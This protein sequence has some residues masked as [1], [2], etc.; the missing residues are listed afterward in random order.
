VQ[1]RKGDS[2][3]ARATLIEA[4]RAAT[5]VHEENIA[6]EAWLE[7]VGIVFFDR[8]MLPELD[9]WILGAE[10]AATRLAKDNPLQTQLAF[11]V[12]SAQLLHG[13]IDDA[14][15]KLER[16]LAE[17]KREPDK[18][19]YDIAAVENSLGVAHLYRG[20][21]DA[22]RGSFKRA[23]DVWDALPVLHPNLASTLSWMGELEVMRHDYAA[24]EPLFERA[25]ETFEALG[26]AGRSQVGKAQLQLG[27]LYAHTDRCKS[28]DEMFAKARQVATGVNGKPSVL[29]GLIDLGEGTCA[30]ATGHSARAI[31][32]LGRATKVETRATLLQ[33]PMTDFALAQA[34][35][36]ARKDH[37]RALELAEG[38]REGFARFPGAEADRKTVEAWLAAQ[39]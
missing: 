2:V 28:A 35:V 12:G 37:R 29:T 24:A 39:R 1:T 33:Q 20:E 38:A 32:L 7:L 27:F 30:L 16:A 18:R 23:L 19:K 4:V 3:G 17:F 21:W 5:T 31:E 8:D 13:D 14:L 9:G 22:A 6:V 11:K 36:A 15:A 34:L 25:V 10:L 26:D